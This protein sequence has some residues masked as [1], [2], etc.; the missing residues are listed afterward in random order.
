M[1]ECANLVNIE[2]PPQS[3]PDGILKRKLD[4]SA[5]EF[6][7]PCK[8]M[9]VSPPSLNKSNSSDGTAN[10]THKAPA[11][12]AQPK[13]SKAEREAI[14]AEKAKE[15]DLERQKR[16]AEKAKR[17]EDKQKKEEE[18]IKKVRNYFEVR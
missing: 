10:G 16:E 2:P 5:E 13:L 11:N 18:R 7:F 1:D 12:P 8:K 9:A 14:K 15:R 3:P 4:G 6:A 17:E